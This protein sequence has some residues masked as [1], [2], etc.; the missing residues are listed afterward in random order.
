MNKSNSKLVDAR[1]KIIDL[2]ELLG[3][4]ILVEDLS[5]KFTNGQVEPAL[6]WAR[7]KVD[8]LQANLEDE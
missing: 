7:Q 3:Y 6:T 1:K 5:K 8:E 4:K 2:E